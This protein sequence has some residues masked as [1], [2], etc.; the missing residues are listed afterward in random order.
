MLWLRL[1][2]DEV[3]RPEKKLFLMFSSCWD[4]FL[5]LLQCST[6]KNLFD[7]SQTASQFYRV[8]QWTLPRLPVLM[9]GPALFLF[10]VPEFS[11][12]FVTCGQLRL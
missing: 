2:L 7:P 4:L 5:S 8:L 1:L 9:L 11:K 10:A 12:A 3:Q 6:P